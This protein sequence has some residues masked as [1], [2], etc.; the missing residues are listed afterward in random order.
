MKPH[1]MQPVYLDDQS[2]ARFRKNK[3]VE[4]LLDKGPF[5]MNHLSMCAAAQKGEF[6]AEDREQFAQLIGYSVS[7]FGD[8]S[9]ADPDT[10]E[11]ADAEVNRLIGYNVDNEDDTI[12]EQYK[13]IVVDTYIELCDSCGAEAPL[14]KFE[15]RNLCEFCASTFIANMTQYPDQYDRSV[16][17]LAV[18]VA[19]I[20]NMFADR[21]EGRKPPKTEEG[22][23]D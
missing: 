18:S 11:R 21:L 2:V 20:A 19:F 3:I 10:V 8:L 5:D 17:T 22:D 12:D 4:Y 23:N 13:Y 9:Y 7:G 15:D 16:R 14:A 6:S 1:P